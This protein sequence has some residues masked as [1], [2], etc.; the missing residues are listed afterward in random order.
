MTHIV[1]YY[2][3]ITHKNLW[4]TLNLMTLW[5]IKTYDTHHNLRHTLLYRKNIF[6][7]TH[8]KLLDN[9]TQC[10]RLY[11]TTQCKMLYHTTQCKLLNHTT[12][13]K[14]LNDTTQC[15][16]LNHTTQCKLL[17]NTTQCKRYVHTFNPT[18]G[19]S[20]TCTNILFLLLKYKGL[21]LQVCQ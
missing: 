13:C 21:T 14:L 5:H 12:Q 16:L 11:H 17:N 6:L 3:I 2:D 1:I 7:P 4:H 15:K 19:C 18:H 9:T 20:S 8:V 10:K